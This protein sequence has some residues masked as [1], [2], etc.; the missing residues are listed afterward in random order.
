LSLTFS[1]LFFTFSSCTILRSASACIA[2][3]SLAKITNGIRI[4]ASAQNGVRL[5][6]QKNLPEI[7][8]IEAVGQNSIPLKIVGQAVVIQD[9]RSIWERMT[10]VSSRYE[11]VI[12]PKT[13]ELIPE[14]THE[15]KIS[16][17]LIIKDGSQLLNIELQFEGG[18]KRALKGG[19]GN[20]EAKI[21]SL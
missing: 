9:T 19:C 14:S 2:Q 20:T 21:E 5:E 1:L 7:I 16:Y 4:I 17:K 15:N 13:L 10:G 18:R 6:G 3:P 8:S 12:I 11:K